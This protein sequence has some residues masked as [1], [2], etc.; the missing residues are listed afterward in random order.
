M[1]NGA[2]AIE[3]YA[4]EPVLPYTPGENRAMK[5]RHYGNVDEFGRIQFIDMEETKGTNPE[6]DA[7][8]RQVDPRT[9]RALIINKVKYTKKK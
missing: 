8:L 9:L 7:R 5:G 4:M 2:S 6:Y 1:T 3:K